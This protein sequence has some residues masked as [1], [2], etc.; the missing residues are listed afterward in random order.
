MSTE[1]LER[2]EAV[3]AEGGVPGG[4]DIADQ[5]RGDGGGSGD[6]NILADPARFGLWLFLGTVTMFFI[7]LTSAYLVRRAASDWRTL[8]LPSALWLNT[9]LL[10]ISSVTL[11]IARR[12]LRGWEL[13]ATGR[14]FAATGALGV[15]FVA[16]QLFVWRDLAARG[17]FLASNPHNSFFYVLTGVHIFHVV[18]GLIWFCVVAWK[19]RRMGLTPGRDGLRLFA[20]Y[21]HYLA[22][23]W[24]YLL[25]VLFW[26]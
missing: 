23:L 2:V 6:R 17:Y 7:G 10:A 14:W 16:S 4:S 24:V 19:L 22:G 1:V 25:C 18:P 13:A 26:I 21:W 9:G 3:T 12:R 15:L 8:P 5:P 11:E 20:T